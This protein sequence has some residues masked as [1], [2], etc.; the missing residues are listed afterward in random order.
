MFVLGTDLAYLGKR[1][2]VWPPPKKIEG[3]R[4]N[5]NDVVGES[6]DLTQRLVGIGTDSPVPRERP[7]PD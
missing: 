3:R 5:R 6:T 7:M 2:L 4:C 1:A